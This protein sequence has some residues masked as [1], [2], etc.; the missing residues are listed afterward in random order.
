MHNTDI[1]VTSNVEGGNLVKRIQSFISK[2][3]LYVKTD[4]H[5]LV[6]LVLNVFFS[7]SLSLSLPSI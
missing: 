1:K 2:V 7:L 4:R 6:H 5:Q 3:C